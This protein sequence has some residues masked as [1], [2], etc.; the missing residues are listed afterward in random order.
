MKRKVGY[1]LLLS[2]SVILFGCSNEEDN[3]KTITY[4]GQIVSDITQEPLCGIRIQLVSNGTK[5]FLTTSDVAGDFEFTLNIQ[6]I[7]STHYLLLTN[8]SDYSQK[9]YLKGF[10][11]GVFDYGIITFYDEEEGNLK[12]FSYGGQKYFVY[13]YF[14]SAS[15]LDAVNQCFNL[16]VCGNDDW[17]LPSYEQLK[18]MD[19]A[20]LLNDH[21]FWSSNITTGHINDSYS[22][23]TNAKCISYTKTTDKYVDINV[24]SGNCYA[25]PIRCDIR[26]EYTY[27]TIR[28]NS[29][30]LSN[31][32]IVCDIVSEQQNGIGEKGICWAYSPMPTTSNNVIKCGS[33]ASSFTKGVDFIPNYDGRRIYIRSYVVVNGDVIYSPS[34]IVP[35]NHNFW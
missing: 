21:I 9:L 22:M 2:I 26:E 17:F 34:V 30:D 18:A 19:T 12:S 4:K 11:M 27:I 10:G 15:W 29:Y 33:G 8:S 3:I 1:W 32:S 14:E 28:I 20:G 13:P 16:D 25:I 31:V 35:E 5:I 23:W 6:D 7:N 24:T